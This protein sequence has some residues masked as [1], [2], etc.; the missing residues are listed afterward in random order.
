MFNF[1]FK[2]PQINVN[3]SSIGLDIH[4]HLIPGIDDGAKS[5]D[6]SVVLIKHIMNMGFTEIITTPHVMSGNYPNTQQDILDG[7]A[8]LQYCLKEK[9]IQIPIS[10][11]AEYFLDEEFL[12]LLESEPLLTLPNNHLLV[13][14][15]QMAAFDGLNDYLFRIQVK[16][17]KTI[18]AHPERYI[19]YH[20]NYEVYETLKDKGVLFQVNILSL[21]GYY[22]KHIKQI[23]LQ[24]LKDNMVELLGTDIHHTRHTKYIHENLLN[25]R[26]L[27]KILSNYEFQND[28]LFIEQIQKTP[29]VLDYIL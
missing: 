20:N 14:V 19:Y 9:S 6:E 24:L 7:L 4:S 29:P 8:S 15:S 1:F 16:G 5:L 13:E 18:L 17:Y 11:A 3:F 21:L 26:E 27:Q 12:E 25:N 23:S 10:A 22:G 2:N 28:T